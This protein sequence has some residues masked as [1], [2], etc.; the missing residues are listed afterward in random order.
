MG[1]HGINTQGSRFGSLHEAYAGRVF[2]E[3]TSAPFTE[4]AAN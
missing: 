3:E 1:M 2:I 4:P